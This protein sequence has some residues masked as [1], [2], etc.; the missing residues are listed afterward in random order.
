MKTVGH[1]SLEVLGARHGAASGVKVLLQASEGYRRRCAGR[2]LALGERIERALVDEP[3][4]LVSEGRPAG[5]PTVLQVW[6]EDG[7]AQTI[8]FDGRRAVLQDDCA[9]RYGRASVSALRRATIARAMAMRYARFDADARALVAPCGVDD[10]IS[11]T[12][13]FASPENW[14]FEKTGRGYRW[15]GH[16]LFQQM[17]TPP[18]STP[19]GSKVTRPRFHDVFDEMCAEKW[20]GQLGGDRGDPLRCIAELRQVREK[21]EMGASP[22][23]G[24]VARKRL[25]EHLCFDLAVA[26]GRCR[27]FGVGLAEIEDFTLT[28]AAA[29]LAAKH[30]I[31]L[32]KTE[33]ELTTGLPGRLSAERTYR[34]RDYVLERLEARMDLWA[35]SVA[36]AEA[37]EASAD[38]VNPN[39][40][41]AGPQSDARVEERVHAG[42]VARMMRVI[43]WMAGRVD[44][45]LQHHVELLKSAAGTYLLTNW[46]RVLARGYGGE[47]WPWWLDG[48]IG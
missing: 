26:L 35:L 42:E 5:A 15:T 3:L 39:A 19:P 23:L 6:Q 38:T 41:Q 8:T 18:T 2:E 16:N 34:E 17:T 37:E 32:F 20:G 48:R 33:L 43:Q 7:R 27:L 4:V 29:R 14:G 24:A 30:A 31:E 46:R 45:N 11:P 1:I 44:G 12:I 22:A 9:T 40:P 36:V 21:A 13:Q 47:A 28:A 25:D 10:Q